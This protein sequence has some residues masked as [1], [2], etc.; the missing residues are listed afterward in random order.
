MPL[1]SGMPFF[2][3]I[4]RTPCSSICP[5]PSSGSSNSSRQ[6]KAWAKTD[7]S[8][9]SGISG[10]SF[11]FEGQ[12]ND[13]ESE[14]EELSTG[15]DSG[16]GGSPV[17]VTSSKLG[18]EDSGFEKRSWLSRLGNFTSDD[19]KTVFVAFATS[20]LFRAYIAEPRFIPS[21]SMFPTFEIGD[22][23][24]AEKVSFESS[25]SAWGFCRRTPW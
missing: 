21:L 7:D 18:E 8:S 24:I 20:L 10:T 17:N 6:F 14:A 19:G 16:D 5:M 9:D 3:A 4:S 1:F 2:Q 22:R 25:H 12:S 15:G 13:Q 11:K 23:I